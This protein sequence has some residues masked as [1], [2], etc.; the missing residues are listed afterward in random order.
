MKI[1]RADKI[2]GSHFL[3]IFVQIYAPLKHDDYGSKYFPGIDDAIEKAKSLSK[4][5]SWHLVQH[6]VW[7]VSRAVRHVSQVLNGELT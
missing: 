7:R 4:P 6:Q 5:E 2:D 3:S 1:H